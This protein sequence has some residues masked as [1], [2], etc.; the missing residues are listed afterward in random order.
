MGCLVFWCKISA[1]IISLISLST[2][3]LRRKIDLCKYAIKTVAF[4]GFLLYLFA[5]LG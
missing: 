5:Q 2:A 1:E 4:L 3:K